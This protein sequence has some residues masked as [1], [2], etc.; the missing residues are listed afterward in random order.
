MKKFKLLTSLCSL[1]AITA[2]PIIATSCSGGQIKDETVKIRLDYYNS[3][4][5]YIQG[6]T[7]W[8]VVEGGYVD[9]DHLITP[10]YWFKQNTLVAKSNSQYITIDDTYAY[11]TGI[12]L[13]TASENAEMGKYKIT[14][15]GEDQEGHKG[16]I[17][18]ALEVTNSSYWAELC[19]SEGWN[20]YGD[21]YY[22]EP[23][24]GEGNDIL[25]IEL[26]NGHEKMTSGYTVQFKLIDP[27]LIPTGWLSFDE[28]DG[29]VI[30][31]ENIKSGDYANFRYE[32]K[33]DSETVCKGWACIFAQW[34]NNI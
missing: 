15:E 4:A 13:I 28:I 23:F 3:D 9:E 25:H 2:A 12:F 16:S 19:D 21:I 24:V 6:M 14:I 30:V 5:Q 18:Y 31:S 8:L 7:G 27:V 29:L 10:D 17:D 22:F 20:T 32:V 26:W 33:V 34:E 11:E 1:G